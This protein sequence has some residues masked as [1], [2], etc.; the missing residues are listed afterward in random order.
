LAVS[1]EASAD[2]VLPD[3][4]TNLATPVPRLIIFLKDRSS[5]PNQFC[6]AN[7]LAE[8]GRSAKDAVPALTAALEEAEP[9]VRM[10]AARALGRI[11]VTSPDAIVA[12]LK[13]AA[14][15]KD[16]D[17][18]RAATEASESLLS[19]F[20]PAA[21]HAVATLKAALKDA[22]SPTALIA[23]LKAATKGKD[24]DLRRAAAE[25]LEGIAHNA[26]QTVNAQDTA[27]M[28]VDQGDSETKAVEKLGGRIKRDD[29]AE[30]KPIIGVSLHSSQLSQL[31][32]A[33]LKEL[34]RLKTLQSL[35]LTGTPV[36]EKG[37]KEL[38]G[39]KNLQELNLSY[40]GVEDATLKQLKNLK[41]LQTLSLNRVTDTTLRTLREIGLLHALQEVPM[42]F[43]IA[44]PQGKDGKRPSNSDDVIAIR[45]NNSISD[46]GL[47][48]IKEFKNL[49]TLL[50]DNNAPITDAGLKE[51]KAFK[52]LRVLDLYGIKIT[53]AG[54]KELGEI[55]SLESLN[56]MFTKVTDSGLKE[57]KNLK[58]LQ[59]LSLNGVTDTTLRTLREMGLLHA[60]WV[61]NARGGKRP[62]GPLD[63]IAL[64]L[65]TVGHV[66]DAGLKE[67]KEL[68][69]LRTLILTRCKV[70]DAGLKELN[71]FKNLQWLDLTY[72]GVSGEGLK[73]LNELK[74]LR[75]LDLDMY[76]GGRTS[77][78]ALRA[79]REIGKLYVL[80]EAQGKDG[81]RPS[82]NADVIELTLSAATDAG[83]KELTDLKNLQ[84]L[85]L[86]GPITDVGL[87][88]L[89]E[90]KHLQTLD[91]LS[92]KVSEAGVVGLQK[93]LPMI[94]IKRIAIPP[95][96]QRQEP[97]GLGAGV[98]FCPS[99]G[100]V[101]LDR[102]V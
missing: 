46:A 72:T 42:V 84:T 50:I 79:L 69:N 91:L 51:L 48:E 7:T 25:A 9:F 35:D 22:D 8:L 5:W 60:L 67:L 76:P 89:A 52:N 20:G 77:D 101:S 81:K 88:E 38:A 102:S 75:L 98:Q 70:T 43:K 18:R 21:K 10:A 34:G 90:L 86:A 2:D 93:A 62:S 14:K 4:P 1:T 99:H 31:L 3:G 85:H 24:S 73:Y 17:V 45:L 61:G 11:G 68:K 47:K 15:D 28:R 16:P 80:R 30:G 41:K 55:T 23:A 32:D 36:T 94:R 27:P 58:N 39:L 64:T 49:Q 40:T 54:L 13:A 71:A 87:K 65:D 19:Q 56:L 57:L 92:D 63:V 97:F 37:L 6:A 96:F 66:T 59:T 29:K 83:L 44:G 33:G 82:G 100:V 74:N 53:D 12:T 26:V 78:A 95:I